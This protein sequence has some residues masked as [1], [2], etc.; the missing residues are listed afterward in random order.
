MSVAATG[1]P[2]VDS[3]TDEKLKQ[4]VEVAEVDKNR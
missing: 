4:F 2:F 1:S 3:M